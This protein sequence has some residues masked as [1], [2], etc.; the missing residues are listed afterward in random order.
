MTRVLPFLLAFL[1]ALAGCAV[2]PDYKR[3]EAPQAT[4]FKEAGGEWIVAQ[5]ADA[6]PKGQWW[7]LFNDPVLDGLVDQAN[8]GSFTLAAAEARYRQATAAIGAARAQLFPTLGVSAGVTR[9]GATGSGTSNQA[10]T[11]GNAISGTAAASRYTVDL[12]ASWEPDL[13]GRVRRQVESARASAQ[14]SQGDLEAA[15]LSLDAELA[16]DYFQLRTTDAEIVLIDDTVKA[17]GTNYKLTQ[18]RYAAGVAGRVDVVQAESQLRGTQAQAIDLKAAR[19]QLEHAIAILMGKPPADVT[20]A[21]V[22]LHFHTPTIPPGIPSTLLQRRP[23]IAAAERRVAAANAQIGVAE[24]AY[25]P[26]LS[27]TGSIGKAQSSFAHLF[28]L[29]NRTWSLGLDL[30]E[31]LLDFGARRSQVEQARA[32]YDETVA[33]YRQTVLTSMQEVEDNL[34][35]MHW[36]GEESQVQAESARAAR[37]SVVLTVNQYKAGTVSF[38]NVALVQAAQLDAERAT[39]T[40]LGRRLAA[41]VGLIR[42]LG[43]TW[44]AGAPGISPAP[45][46]A[47]AGPAAR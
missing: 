27:L 35:A 29:S 19:A 30:A 38:L 5:P 42:A 14:A 39:V 11:S 22:D 40:L 12:N 17:F 9:A 13:W 4:G 41:T 7:T 26:N 43:G 34:A 3:P 20:I 45:A 37:E 33:N 23:D 18:N 21:P 25:F 10:G 24:A 15:R 47:A 1:L 28:S 32:A 46:G 6:V 2:G 8:G 31:T 16:T 36:L 44:D